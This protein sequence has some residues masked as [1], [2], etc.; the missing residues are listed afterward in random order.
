MGH[1]RPRSVTVLAALAAGVFTDIVMTVHSVQFAYRSVAVHAML[2]VTAT[3]IAFVTTVLLWGRLKYRRGLDDLLLFIA[4]AFLSVTSLL[5][6]VIPAAIW[7]E[8]H[9]FSTWTTL[10]TSGLSAAVLAAA[11]LAPSV[12]I[13]DYEH[14]GRLAVIGMTAA[15]VVI[16]VVVGALV[17]HLPVGIDPSRSPLNVPGPISGNFIIAGVQLVIALLFIVAAMGFTRRAEATGD[18]FFLWLGAGA[19]FAAFSRV[20]YVVFPSLY[21]EWVYTGDILRFGWHLLLFIGAVREIRVYQRAYAEARV[22]EERRRIAR[23][24]HDG[25]AQELAFIANRTR[26]LSLGPVTRTALQQV[27]SAAQRGLDESR[28]AIQTLTTISDEPFDVALVQAVEEVADRLG[29]NVEIEA[30]PAPEMTS[31]QREQLLR[32]VREAVTNA[33]RHANADLVRVQFTNG[34]P[35]H[36]RVED[37]GAGFDVDD[38]DGHGFGLVTMEERALAIGADFSVSS[39]PGRGTAVEVRL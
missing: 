22:L 27:A 38:T 8:P 20:N 28:R 30:E 21:S 37:D 26:E 4:I 12:R 3:L 18:E 7:R 15:L 13:R 9:P 31:E 29:A 14:L 19:V 23:D 5:F 35:L 32:I 11:A 1:L 17:D 36:L 2:E 24:L 25:L 6:A 34:G 16:G 33:S 10:I 39:T